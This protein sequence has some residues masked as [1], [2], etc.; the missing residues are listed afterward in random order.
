MDGTTTEPGNSCTY[1]NNIY[2]SLAGC[3]DVK[4]DEPLLDVEVGGSYRPRPV[5]DPAPG[6]PDEQL[7]PEQLM[8]R[9][10]ARCQQQL[11]V[12]LYVIFAKFGV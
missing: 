9:E 5:D 4:V 10:L 12:G 8:Q 3:L 11:H 7:T 1:C 2:A 6:V